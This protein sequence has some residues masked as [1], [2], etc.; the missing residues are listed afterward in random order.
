[1]LEPGVLS[2]SEVPARL[3]EALGALAGRLETLSRRET[4][5]AT[6]LDELHGRARAAIASAEFRA[7]R[8]LG[9]TRRIQRELERI[10]LQ[11]PAPETRISSRANGTPEPGDGGRA[12]GDGSGFP[13]P[14]SS[15]ARPPEAEV[16][17]ARTKD[18]LLAILRKKVE[19]EVECRF[20]R[21]RA[22]ALEQK[23]EELAR[24]EEERLADRD[25]IETYK[26]WLGRMREKNRK[27]RDESETHRILV[28][29][30]MELLARQSSEVRDLRERVLVIQDEKSHAIGRLRLLEGRL[31]LGPGAA[32]VQGVEAFRLVQGDTWQRLTVHFDY[33]FDISQGY[34]FL[35]YEHLRSLVRKLIVGLRGDPGALFDLAYYTNNTYLKNHSLNVAKLAIYLG[36]GCGYPDSV[37]EVLGISA[38]LHDIGMAKVPDSILCKPSSLS[39]DEWKELR[40]HPDHGEDLFRKIETSGDLASHVVA[41]VAREHHERADGSGYPY[42]KTSP[43]LHEF[44][45][46]ISIADSYEAMTS[47]RAHR[48]GLYPHE[49][50]KALIRE[51]RSGKYDEGLVKV[52]V[53]S[54]SIYPI[55]SY[56]RLSTGEVAR[57]VASSQSSVQRPIVRIVQGPDGRPPARPAYLD[58][59]IEEDVR[60]TTPHA[61]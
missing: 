55:G 45:K 4:E 31:G 54:M 13:R 43:D 1:M 50:M 56:V 42:G 58:L 46:I 29:E 61:R 16:E 20:L 47:P 52:F 5:A 18:T 11:E 53:R 12:T 22:E 9:D 35:D 6:E 57:V 25:R 44:S 24:V 26:S 3:Q 7:S 28:T 40:K 14:P 27:L 32:G 39:R 8:I 10:E 38:L 49:A 51:T 2:A 41:T 48:S 23:A 60:I 15:V 19:L 21:E 17:L 59:S 30:K 34:P 37:L 33:L 36:L